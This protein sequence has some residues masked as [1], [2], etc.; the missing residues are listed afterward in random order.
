MDD[1]HEND[2]FSTILLDRNFKLLPLR[3]VVWSVVVIRLN[4]VSD[5]RAIFR[6]LYWFLY[7]NISGFRARVKPIELC[8]ILDS[9]LLPYKF[10]P[11]LLKAS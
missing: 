7:E 4:K 3:P 6:V 9:D 1:R 11:I 2:S 8:F 10:V 5:N